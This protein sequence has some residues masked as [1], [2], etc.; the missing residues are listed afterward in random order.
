MFW[1]L[2]RNSLEQDMIQLSQLLGAFFSYAATQDGDSLDEASFC[3]AFPQSAAWFLEQLHG[4]QKN[5]E[6][7]QW[8]VEKLFLLPPARRQ[9]IAQA[10]ANDLAF[11]Q[12]ADPEHFCFQFPHLPAQERLIVEKFFCY[13]Y[14]VAFHRK[15]GPHINGGVSG[16]TR[17]GFFQ[18]YSQANKHLKQACPVCLHQRSS[19]ARENTLEHYF[20]KGLYPLLILHPSNLFFVCRDCNETYKQATDVRKEKGEPL[21]KVFLPYRDTI[22]DHAAITFHRKDCTD[23]VKLLS[24]SGTEEEQEKINRFSDLYHLEERWT[25]DTEG[26]L[27][28]FRKICANQDWSRERAREELE[29]ICRNLQALSEFPDKFLETAY[30]NWICDTMFDAFY[31][32]L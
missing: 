32:S 16:A 29:R 4:R 3:A 26:I 5:R 21:S 11:D 25:G 12:T 28:Q 7:L 18:A 17:D 15:G 24:V 9:K 19:A 23:Q 14:N 31:D 8:A 22:K 30:A 6:G 20:P 10:V 2:H 13:F 1:E 27:E